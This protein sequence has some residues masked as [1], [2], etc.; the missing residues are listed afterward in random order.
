MQQL[1]A[2]FKVFSRFIL[3]AI[4]AI[5][6]L[7]SLSHTLAHMHTAILFA[8]EGINYVQ[9]VGGSGTACLNRSQ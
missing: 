6:I 9:G 1:P 8:L 7:L 5:L 4:H 2:P 3:S